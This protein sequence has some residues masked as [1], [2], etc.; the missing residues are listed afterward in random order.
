[1]H[2]PAKHTKAI[3]MMLRDRRRTELDLPPG[4]CPYLWEARRDMKVHNVVKGYCP[5]T[6]GT[7]SESRLS[8]REAASG[9]SACVDRL[10]KHYDE[11]VKNVDIRLLLLG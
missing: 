1:M 5:I 10:L 4:G 7:I 6:E 8:R 11:L 3:I 2:D 9:Q